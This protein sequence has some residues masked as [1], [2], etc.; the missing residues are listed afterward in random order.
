MSTVSPPQLITPDDS[1][2]DLLLPI[3]N[4]VKMSMSSKKATVKN[5]GSK[6]V[7]ILTDGDINPDI[8]VVYEN[9]CQDHFEEK[10]YTSND[11]VKKILGGLQ[12][13]LLREWFTADRTRIQSLSFLDFMSEVRAEFLDNNWE[14][15]AEQSLLGMVQGD[16][17]FRDFCRR[18]EVAN[19]KLARTSSHLN[20]A[21]LRQQL[22][23]RMSGPLH[24]CANNS[25]A[26]YQKDYKLWKEEVRKIDDVLVATYTE[27]A[28]VLRK[29]C[30][31][32]HTTSVLS[33]PS[34][35]ANTTSALNNKVSS[36]NTSTSSKPP[37]LTAKEKGLLMK[38]RGC[39]KCR[40]LDQS[41]Q[42]RDCPN[43]FPSGVGYRELTQSD[44]PAGCKP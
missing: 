28:E 43:G 26:G 39:F 33:E 38:Y 11:Q 2:D 31:A 14:D 34:R 23:A 21:H 6:Y 20:K 30:L 19:A 15:T 10:G 22:T 9:A 24:M 5:R 4:S 29:Q 1:S 7:P 12:G 18:L 17:T 36:T 27:F 42:S 40:R 25:T 35:K 41:H 8:L 37:Q 3:Y 16:D 13:A 44:V 32:N